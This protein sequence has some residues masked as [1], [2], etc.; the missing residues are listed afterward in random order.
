MANLAFVWANWSSS[1][2]RTKLIRTTAFFQCGTP[3]TVNFRAW[4]CCQPVI[5]RLTAR[6]TRRRRWASGKRLKLVLTA[7]AVKAVRFE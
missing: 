5:L 3:P 6:V 4:V 2:E 1:I 7:P